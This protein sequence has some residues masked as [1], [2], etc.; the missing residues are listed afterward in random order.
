MLVH[1][2]ALDV[3]P[4]G[5]VRGV[6]VL[7]SV[8]LAG[9]DDPHRRPDLLHHT[10]LHGRGVGAQ[11]NLARPDLVTD[12]E[13]IPHV[14]RGVVRRDVQQ[15]EVIA[16]PLDLG[17][18]HCPE[19]QRREHAPD[20]TENPGQGMQ[21]AQPNGIARHGDVHPLSGGLGGAQGLQARLQ[22]LLQLRLGCVGGLAGGPAL[23][24]WELADG[25]QQPGQLAAAAEVPYAPG[26]DGLAVA[27]VLEIA[28]RRADQF[29]SATLQ[30]RCPPRLWPLRVD[31][32]PQTG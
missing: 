17:T 16:V 4:L 24:R 6:A 32:R 14:P 1:G 19:A 7:V 13:G 23:L 12:V 2:Q 29:P 18:F 9:D 25:A 22:G 10:R 15:L 11:Q 8:R 28:Q 5:F 27:R 20:F 30:T 21:R 3:H 26:F 31:V